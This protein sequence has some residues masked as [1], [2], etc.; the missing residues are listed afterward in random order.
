MKLLLIILSA[1][2]LNT[3][4]FAGTK[5]IL[6]EIADHADVQNGDTDVST[7]NLATFKLQ[8]AIIQLSRSLPN[9]NGCGYA[10]SGRRQLSLDSLKDIN[11]RDEVYEALQDLHKKGLVRYMIA[12]TNNEGE[13]ENCSIFRFEIF[14]TDG[15]VLSLNY[16]WTT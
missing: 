11:A 7:Y 3:A 1:I 13:S 16:D 8:D 10:T 12:R 5:E 6:K 14:T 2:T 9:R 15:Y 4:A